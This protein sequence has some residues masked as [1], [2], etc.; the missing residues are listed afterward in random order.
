MPRIQWR[1]THLKNLK[2]CI[3]LCIVLAATSLTASAGTLYTTDTLRITFTTSSP[4]CPSGPC[5]SLAI[6]PSGTLSGFFTTGI[7][8]NLFDGTNLLGTDSNL[9]FCCTSSFRSASSLS[10]QGPV[11]DFTAI[12]NGLINGVID[13]RILGPSNSFLSW[14]GNPVATVILSHAAGPGNYL[15]GTGLT[16]TSVS[17][18]TPE[19]SSGATVLLS[20]GLIF[21]YRKRS[22][23]PYLKIGQPYQR[24]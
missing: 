21:L 14:P 11:V 17:I 10:T 9:S 13:I 5:D 24:T 23:L 12:N 22:W 15:A 18:N 7:T 2:F 4:S 6:F 19:P 20:T 16:I 8:T 1:E 3:T